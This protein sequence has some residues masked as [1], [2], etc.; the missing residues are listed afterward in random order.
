MKA[1]IFQINADGSRGQAYTGDS[2]EYENVKTHRKINEE[3]QY[4]EVSGFSYKTIAAEEGPS[5][6]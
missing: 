3:A 6:C 2:D 5:V 4:N 1:L